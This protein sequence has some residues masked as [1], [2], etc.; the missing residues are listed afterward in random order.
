MSGTGR[1][2]GLA[3][4][5]AWAAHGFT[6]DPAELLAEGSLPRAWAAR[7]A[8]A[9]GSPDA[10]RRRRRVGVGRRAR[11][12]HG[13]GGGPARRRGRGPRRPGA[14]ELPRRSVDLVVAHV[15]AL[16]LGAVVVPVNTGFGPGE[17]GNVWRES[18]PTLAVLDDPA[19]AAPRPRPP[20]PDVRPARRAAAVALDAAGP[21][22]PAL[23]VF[24][25]GT[26]G[27]P[28]GAVLSHGNLLSSAEAL[29]RAWRWTPDD[30]L[31]LALPLFHMHGL[32]VGVHG[33]LLAGA[34][35]V[36]RA[37]VRAPTPSL[38]AVGHRRRP[39]CS[40]ACPPCTCRLAASPAGGRAGPAAPVRLGSAPLAAD[41][42][43]D[44]RRG[45]A[46]SGCSSATA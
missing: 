40:S 17:L 31:V 36:H 13:R 2:E 21:D 32:G 27:R 46:A 4:A 41:L 8:A 44:A 29:R 33:T 35:A 16:R 42:W 20:R 6:S 43:H 39:R 15:A 37:P 14:H 24:T 26:T 22:D 19:P 34:S 25:S 28:K 3:D 11:G 30:R 10:G 5:A 7:W 18:R 23:L 1:R 9:P 38:D 12:P 45:G